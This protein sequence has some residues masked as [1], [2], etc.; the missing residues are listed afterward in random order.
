MIVAIY[1]ALW[2][3]NQQQRVATSAMLESNKSIPA[4]PVSS[5]ICKDACLYFKAW[6][7]P[8]VLQWWESGGECVCVCV[9]I[10]VCVR[11]GEQEL[12]SRGKQ[13]KKWMRRHNFTLCKY[14]A[15]A[16]QGSVGFCACIYLKSVILERGSSHWVFSGV[17]AASWKPAEV[18]VLEERRGFVV[19]GTLSNTK[20]NKRICTLEHAVINLKKQ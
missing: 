7:F 9:W 13:G 15:K 12:C 1:R 19:T 3:C 17:V 14:L 2:W 5:L 20:P 4:F 18:T 10:F 6:E 8:S 16:R 11:T